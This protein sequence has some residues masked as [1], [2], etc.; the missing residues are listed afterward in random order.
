MAM[1]S[2]A[3][4]TAGFLGNPKASMVPA[5]QA[6]AASSAEGDE[7]TDSGFGAAFEA[8]RRYS[9]EAADKASRDNAVES[10]EDN[11][12]DGPLDKLG[13]SGG[14]PATWES[15]PDNVDAI[16][17]AGDL[18]LTG[19]ALTPE[20]DGSGFDSSQAVE[21]EQNHP[22][23]D[24]PEKTDTTAHVAA[25]AAAVA[26]PVR[27]AAGA[28][29]NNKETAPD[30]VKKPATDAEFSTSRDGGT[31][32]TSRSDP[33]ADLRNLVRA[34]DRQQS[35]A[36][37]FDGPLNM[38]PVPDN[39]DIKSPEP[40]PLERSPGNL[41]VS[42]RPNQA[43]IRDGGSQPPVNLTVVEARQ[44]PGLAP[45]QT[46]ASAV[47]NAI[48]SH[49]SWNTMLRGNEV[50]S[51]N[52]FNRPAAQLNTLKIQLNPAE[53]GSV[54]AILRLSGDQL[55]INLKVET[56]EAYRQL[57]ESQNAVLKALKGQGYTIEQITIQQV[58]PDRPVPQQGG[59]AGQTTG[60]P[61]GQSGQ[62][63]FAQR[64]GGGTGQGNGHEE[65]FDSEGPEPVDIPS[66]SSPRVV[67]DRS[68]YL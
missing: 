46:S 22:Q 58:A 35:P 59:F 4:S 64:D 16:P 19:G 65:R 21:P 44:F 36:K 25:V 57:S 30:L 66:S 14:D 40:A 18:L 7:S 15:P 32:A 67:A 26:V 3:T 61:H 63:N 8:I 38:T 20:E 29:P 37:S 28:G 48:S 39:S 60:G 27:T 13:A 24:E 55:V 23:D 34:A 17:V 68:V 43:A 5:G 45:S 9:R 42:D 6:R 11:S 51:A 2:S 33:F 62:D 41:L 56:V 10:P 1:T 52:M 54:N 31:A 12:H 50:N 53:L 49:E 47:A